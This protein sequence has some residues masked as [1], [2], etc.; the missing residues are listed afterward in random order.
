[1]RLDNVKKAETVRHK[2]IDSLSAVPIQSKVYGFQFN[3][4]EDRTTDFMTDGF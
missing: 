3:T 2:K 4:I 1:M